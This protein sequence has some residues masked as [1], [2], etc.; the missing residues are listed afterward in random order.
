MKKELID[1]EYDAFKRFVSWACENGARPI[2]ALPESH[3]IRILEQAEGIA[4]HSALKKGLREA[5]NDIIEKFSAWPEERVKAA[6]EDLKQLGGPT[7]TEMR[8]LFAL[9][10]KRIENRG[11]I[12]TEEEC[13]LVRNAL[14]MPM[15]QASHKRVEK[16]REMLYE[17]E[18]G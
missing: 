16:F 5:I 12:E 2:D 9:D 15:I 6:D 1:K 4:P 14:E 8:M 13:F 3:P 10:L 11:K 17:Y 7:L 18:F